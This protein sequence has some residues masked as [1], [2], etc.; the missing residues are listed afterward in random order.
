[1]KVIDDE[2]CAA[3]KILSELADLIKTEYG[4]DQKMILSFDFPEYDDYNA[5]Q[6]RVDNGVQKV[7]IYLT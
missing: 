7:G 6:F 5:V 3:F 4:S 2:N 1:M